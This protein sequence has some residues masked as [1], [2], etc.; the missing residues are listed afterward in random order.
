MGTEERYESFVRDHHRPALARR[1]AD[2]HAGSLLPLLHPGLRLL[3]LGCGPAT[4]TAGLHAGVSPGG[5]AVGVDRRRDLAGPVPLARADIHRLPFADATFDAVFCC[6]VLQHVADPPAVLVEAWRVCRPG[7]VIRLVDAD[8]GGE[9]IHPEDPWLARGTEIQ[10][11]LRAGTS[12]YVGRRLRGLLHAA[13]FVDAVAV[14][15]TQGGGG[16]ATTSFAE[17]QATLFEAPAAIERVVNAGIASADEMAAVARA[18]RRWAA[19]PA[20]TMARHGFEATA[21]KPR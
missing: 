3:D 12:R 20:A 16:P 2:S 6:A 9:L 11:Q 5:M 21:R 18:W 4:I 14:S 15:R 13:G 1:T 19:D 8:W 7:A 10:G 17:H